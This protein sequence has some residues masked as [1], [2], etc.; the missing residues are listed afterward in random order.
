MHF[1]R[2]HPM[3]VFV[4]YRFLLAALIIAVWAYAGLRV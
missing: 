3:N 4:Y 1:L 2:S